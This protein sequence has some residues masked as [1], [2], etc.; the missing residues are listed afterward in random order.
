[1]RACKICFVVFA[2]LWAAPFCISQTDAGH[3]E[4]PDMN[5][6][7]NR[8]LAICGNA[9][10]TLHLTPVGTTCLTYVIGLSDG[11][12]MFAAKGSVKEM[13]CPPEGVTHGQVF[14]ILVKYAKDHPE[15][16][17]VETRLLMLWALVE[18]FPCTPSSPPKK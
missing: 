11:I 10:D 14:R 3:L 1:M 2:L 16:L 15:K 8:F 17:S 9:M 18:A 12:G 4:K 5:S 6:S 13:Y 7:G